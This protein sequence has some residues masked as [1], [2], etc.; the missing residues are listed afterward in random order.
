MGASRESGSNKQVGLPYQNKE[1]AMIIKIDTERFNQ[2]KEIATLDFERWEERNTGKK[3][4]YNS[5]KGCLVGALA[6]EAAGQYIEQGYSEKGFN[7]AN[8]KIEMNGHTERK[9]GK[10]LFDKA[11]IEVVGKQRNHKY[12]VKGIAAGQPRGQVTIY[13][14]N[15]YLKNGVD[16]VIFVEVQVIGE[17]AECYI[18]LNESPTEIVNNWTVRPNRFK[19]PCY[20]YPAYATVDGTADDEMF[21]NFY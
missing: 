8:F 11:D 20:T 5:M 13:H 2:I 7:M 18:Y 16:R 3:Q 21:F 6:E 9:T 12:E 19:N 15:K 17:T 10:Q 14:G 4:C 1:P